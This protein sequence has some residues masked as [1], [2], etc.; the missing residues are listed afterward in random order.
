MAAILGRYAT[1][2]GKQM[3]YDEALEKGK[4]LLPESWAWDAKPPIEPNDDGSYPVAVPGSFNPF[5]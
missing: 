4:D 1:Y 5:A 3:K 2:S